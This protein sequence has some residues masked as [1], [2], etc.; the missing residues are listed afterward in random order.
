MEKK[1][2]PNKIRVVLAEKRKTNRRLAE[3]MD[4]AEMTVSRW[5]KNRI[6]PSIS[7]LIEI[8]KLLDVKLDDL[9]EPYNE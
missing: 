1:I 2:Y 6:Q 8:S 3:Q 4:V 7:Q 5:K 9:L